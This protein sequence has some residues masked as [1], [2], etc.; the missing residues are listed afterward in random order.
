MSRHKCIKDTKIL[1]K[2]VLT[3]QNVYDIMYSQDI[4]CIY[5]TEKGAINMENKKRRKE[6]IDQIAKSLSDVPLECIER[7]K[8]ISD[9]MEFTNKKNKKEKTKTA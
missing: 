5:K 6:L 9:A 2:I 1:I 7:I 3:I 8:D 4:K